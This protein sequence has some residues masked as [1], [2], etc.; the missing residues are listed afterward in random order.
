M[1]ENILAKAQQKRHLDFLVMT[2]GRFDQA[3]P[4]AEGQ[5]QGQGQ[6]AAA[7]AAEPDAGSVFTASGLRDILGVGPG[8]GGGGGEG[9]G[10][11]AGEASAAEVEAAMAAAEDAEDIAAMVTNPRQTSP[12]PKKAPPASLGTAIFAPSPRPE[13]VRTCAP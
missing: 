6:P 4:G 11:G 8:G 3:A 5:G 7:P 1:E 13:G 10:E 2:E 12:Q 9:A